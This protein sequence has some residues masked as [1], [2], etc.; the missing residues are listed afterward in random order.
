M[1]KCCA[2]RPATRFFVKVPTN[3]G[4]SWTICHNLMRV[5][6]KISFMSKGMSAPRY[7]Y[8]VKL[9]GLP[10]FLSLFGFLGINIFHL[11]GKLQIKS[12]LFPGN[13]KPQADK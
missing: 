7:T 6:R 4:Y 5:W 1:V 13:S 2:N 11:Q 9:H 3:T 8:H 10:D 12:I